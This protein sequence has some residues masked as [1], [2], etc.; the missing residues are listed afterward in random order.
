MEHALLTLAGYFDTTPDN[1]LTLLNR[2]FELKKNIVN[3]EIKKDTITKSELILPYY[4]EINS[5]M[6]KH[7]VYNHGLYTQCNE[8]CILGIS[9]KKCKN[10]KYGTVYDRQKHGIGK[11]ITPSGKKELDY[12]SFILKMNYN[13]N[14]IKQLFEKLNINYPLTLKND[15]NKNIEKKR[16]GRPC[17]KISSDNQE[18]NKNVSI[19]VE[20]INIGGVEYLITSSCILLDSISYDIVG[21]L[22]DNDIILY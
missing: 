22:E 7:L 4:G 9:C 2:N 3:K 10:N 5:D 21:V 11:Y 12:N 15:C 13:I 20:K 8:K 16:R 14:D 17:K 6:C 19:E 18:I 1:I